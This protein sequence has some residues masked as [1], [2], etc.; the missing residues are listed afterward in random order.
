LSTADVARIA[1]AF[2]LPSHSVLLDRSLLDGWRGSE[3]A[4]LSALRERHGWHPSIPPYYV[5]W[6]RGRVGEPPEERTDASRS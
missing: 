6:L 5:Y 1:Q 3:S 2:E 4:L